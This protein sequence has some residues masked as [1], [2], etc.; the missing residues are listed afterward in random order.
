MVGTEQKYDFKEKIKELETY[1]EENNV[2][3]IE[4]KKLIK[5]YLI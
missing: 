4:L 3:S 5:Y 1:L 2:D